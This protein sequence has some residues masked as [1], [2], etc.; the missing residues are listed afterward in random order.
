[1]S[2]NFLDGTDIIPHF[3]IHFVFFHKNITNWQNI[4]ALLCLRYDPC[5]NTGRIVVGK[6]SSLYL[7]YMNAK[8]LYQH[9]SLCCV[10]GCLFQFPN[11]FRHADPLDIAAGKIDPSQHGL[12]Q[13]RAGQIYILKFHF[14]NA[15][16][17]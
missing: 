14:C 10:N 5:K 16:I 12:E 15:Q 9:R 1:M 6:Q 7:F 3:S 4:P 11:R 2:V 8:Q 17:C 13:I